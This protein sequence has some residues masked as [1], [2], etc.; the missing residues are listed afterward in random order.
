LPESKEEANGFI[1]I[2]VP[3]GLGMRRNILVASAAD[4]VIAIGGR[5]GTLSEVSY[6]TIFQIPVVL[7]AGTGGVVEELAAGKL[8]K[9]SDFPLHVARSAEEAV[10]KAFSLIQKK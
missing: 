9:E 6:A 8:M 1:D 3:T 4:V 7:V 2:P 10:E 5:W